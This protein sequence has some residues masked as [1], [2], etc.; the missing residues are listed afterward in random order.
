ML[1]VIPVV[2]ISHGDGQNFFMRIFFLALLLALPVH[3]DEGWKSAVASLTSG[4]TNQ[5]RVSFE[6]WLEA[7]PS[8]AEAHFNLALACWGEKDPGCASYELL[9]SAQLRSSPLAVW[10]LAEKVTAIEREVGMKDGISADLMFRAYLIINRTWQL[11]FGAIGFWLAV[12][13]TQL[14]LT[15]RHALR[16]APAVTLYLIAIIF[17]ATAGAGWANCH[18]F[19]HYAVLAGSKPVGVPLLRNP[20]A[21]GSADDNTEA[22]KLADLPSGVVVT[23]GESQKGVTRILSPI[24]GWVANDSFKSL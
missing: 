13:A 4:N 9:K 8:S 6:K 12:A 11:W 15:R 20:A 17:F 22:N 5:A 1:H 14:L 7:N 2:V 24:S 23:I 18:Y 21:A 19:S 10:Q 16:L 3:A